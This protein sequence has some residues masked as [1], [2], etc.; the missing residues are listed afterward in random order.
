MI[1]DYLGQH[2]AVELL[3]DRSL[4]ARDI[5]T[6]DLT[7]IAAIYGHI[8]DTGKATELYKK[9]LMIE[10]DNIEVSD[11]L[12]RIDR[13]EDIEIFD[14]IDSPEDGLAETMFDMAR[15]LYADYS[16]ESARIFGHLALYLN[17][18]KM[19]AMMLLWHVSA[20]N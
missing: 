8:G 18:N 1:A 19:N 5:S 4:T 12:E 11:N 3:L 13:G 6:S 7:R 15:I 17:P 16:D 10:P 14:K 9:V 2:E 20:R